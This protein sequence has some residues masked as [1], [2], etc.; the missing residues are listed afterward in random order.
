MNW[1][2]CLCWNAVG[3]VGVVVVH[4]FPITLCLFSFLFSCECVCKYVCVRVCVH[5]CTGAV[6]VVVR[7]R[8]LVPR[9]AGWRLARV[10][11]CTVASS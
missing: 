3:A 9:L 8:Q 10:S 5:R 2:Q 1:Q 7:V 6:G 4:F 11:H